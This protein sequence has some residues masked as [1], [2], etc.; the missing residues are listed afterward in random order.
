MALSWVVVAKEA[1]MV[2]DRASVVRVAGVDIALVCTRDGVVAMDNVCPHSG[3]SLGDGQ[4]EGGVVTCPLHGWQF[5]CRSGRSLTERRPNQKTYPVKVEGGQVLVQ[6]AE[7]AAAPSAP[8]P[9]WVA[10]ADAD[11]LQP[12][13]VRAVALDGKPIALAVTAEGV[14]AVDNACAHEGGPLAEGALEARTLTCPLH[15]YAFD[16]RSGACLSDARLK[17]RTYAVKIEDGKV[18]LRA[19]ASSPAAAP[20]AAPDGDPATR[21]SPAE[22]WKAKKHGFDVWPDVLRYAKDRTPMSKIESSDLERMKWYGFFYRKNNDNDRYMVRVRIPG[23][24]MTFAQAR[25]LATIAYQS[26]YGLLDV[27]T[28]G[29]VQIQGLTVDA[30]P[31]VQAALDRVGLTSRQSGHDNVRNVTSHPWSGFDP[32]ELIDTRALARDVQDMFIGDRALSDLPRKV[33][34]ALTGRAEAPGH[35]WTQ[36]VSFVAARSDDGSVGFQLLLAGTQGQSPHL[37]WHVP[38]FVRPDDVVAVTRAILHTF[39]EL[40]YRHDRQHVRM[41]YLVERIGADGMLMEVERRLGRELERLPRPVPHALHEETFAGWK[42]QRQEGLFALGVCIPV[43]RLTAEEMDG[44]AAVAGQFG[45]GTLRTTY[46]QS[47][48]LPGIAAADRE[49]AAYAVA[50]HGLTFEPDPASRSMVACTGKQFCNIAVIETKGYAYRLIEEM[51][52]RRV[53]LHGIRI[54]MSG[55]PSNCANGFTAEIGLKGLKVR[56]GLRVLD[57][58]D[59]FLGGGVGEELMMGALYRKA[60]PFEELPETLEAVVREFHLQR[61]PGDTFTA[62]WQRRLKR[63]RPEPLKVEVPRWQCTR[64]RHLHVAQDPPAFCPMCAAVRA[65][66]EPAPDEA[67]A[68]AADHGPPAER[69]APP[70]PKPAKK[71]AGRRIVVVGGG[72]AGHVAAEAA[73]AADPEARVTIL[74][75]E[76]AFYNRLNLTRF[77]AREIERDALF[78]YPPAWYEEKAVELQVGT[79]IGLDP[80]QKALLLAEGRE[81]GYDALVLAHGSSAAAPPF[82]REG[83][84]GLRVL[85]TLADAEAVAAAAKDGTRVVVVGGGVLG[86]EAAYGARLRGAL[87][88]VL[89]FMP[90]LMPRQLDV[91][92]AGRL[93]D[94]LR[95]AGIEVETGSAVAEIAGTGRADGVRLADGRAF[96]ADLVVVSTGIRPNVEW[97]KRSGLRCGRGIVVDDRMKTSAPD[98]FAAGDVCE[99]RGQV[100]GLWANAVDQARVAGAGAAGGMAFYEGTLPV[101]VLKCLPLAVASI[102]EIVEDGGDITSTVIEDAQRGSYKKVVFRAGVPVG[103]LLVGTSAGLG[104]LRKLVA[105]GQDLLRLR[106]RVLPAPEPASAVS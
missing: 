1:D 55:C 54:A 23:C 66:F 19:P 59:V 18:W 6:V 53:Q 76:A 14:F 42:P 39:R 99:W 101:T 68:A 47:L 89:E 24:E 52:R 93:A 85:R 49:E 43:G 21:K 41:R 16:L 81:V 90:R 2:P 77:L 51:R 22:A 7:A 58:F 62:F 103:A 72:I 29:N 80:V 33:N 71:P 17:Q 25:A 69:A 79:A 4:V 88:R 94:A 10:V 86:L 106:A 78:D 60:V 5:E 57:A 95:S 97:V 46:D 12:G 63:Q 75:D 28:R 87:V 56:H 9:T 36:D 44:L 82:Y 61:D 84:A 73:R 38:V 96:P 3:G 98:V 83:L 15:G 32:E 45:D 8:N 102:G 37:A 104:E 34:V 105:G 74:S 35:A 26:G 13:S 65:K 100:A 20:A 27:T 40:G 67:G 11:A 30:L 31:A 70:E 91:A 92:A 50:R 48:V 64:C